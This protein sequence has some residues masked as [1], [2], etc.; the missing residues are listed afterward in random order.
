[1]KNIITYLII[2]ILF[3][4]LNLNAN[5]SNSIKDTLN[6]NELIEKIHNGKFPYK[7]TMIQRGIYDNYKAR[8]GLYIKNKVIVGDFRIGLLNRDIGNKKLYFENVFFNNDVL[9]EHVTLFESIVFEKVK[10]EG[11]FSII[12][13]LFQDRFDLIDSKIKGQTKF[14][15]I[16]FKE[17]FVAKRDTFELKSEF[18]N[19][20]FLK[21]T[22]FSGCIFKS[23]N[24]FM[25]NVFYGSATFVDAFSANLSD[26][27]INSFKD[28]AWF[29]NSVFKDLSFRNN[30]FEKRFEFKNVNI[31][32][33]KFGDTHFE[34]N[35]NF[36]SDTIFSKL[37]LKDCHFERTS[38]FIDVVFPDTILIS[39]ISINRML[40]NWSQI[41]NRIYPHNGSNDFEDFAKIY[42]PFQTNFRNLGQFDDEDKCYYKLRTIARELAWKNY[43]RDLSWN[44]YTW[45]KP[46]LLG[47]FRYT[48]GYGVKPFRVLL[49]SLGAILIFTLFFYQ[50]GAIEEHKKEIL[51]FQ[52]DIR[53]KWKRLKDAFYFSVNT[54]TTVGYGDWYPTSKKS[55]LR[56]ISFRS[57]AII[58][59]AFGWFLMA[60]FL[61]TMGKTF[62]R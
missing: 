60:L 21:K 41:E 13:C 27:A 49:F 43:K 36:S 48:C 28:M 38:I 15:N 17:H 42:V 53:S 45:F 61:I 14:E 52:V 46:I 59:G 31:T 34:K 6:A 7:A 18:N 26:F 57:L 30:T 19:I 16:I 8:G 23:R 39:N 5:D 55:F 58:E 33:A 50:Y 47:L 3:Q 20:D 4:T 29:D 2:A 25:G 37:E 40:L 56:F 12:N 11:N 10:F 54:F 1:M 24:S 32:T 44:P 51:N 62:I 35:S 9:L 22:Y